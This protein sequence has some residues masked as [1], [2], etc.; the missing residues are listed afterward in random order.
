MGN[1]GISSRFPGTFGL[2]NRR[3]QKAYLLTGQ[4][5]F[6]LRSTKPYLGTKFTNQ[7]FPQP[8]RANSPA[9]THPNSTTGPAYQK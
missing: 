1:D 4:A 7:A 8:E 3:E 2:P 5:C 6:G 9:S